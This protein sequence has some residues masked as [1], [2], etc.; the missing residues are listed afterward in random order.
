V[1][2]VVAAWAIAA[3]VPALEEDHGRAEPIA[4]AAGISRVAVVETA[5]PSEVV[6]GDLT[7]PARAAAVAVGLPA[8]ALGVEEVSRVVEAGVAAE[9]GADSGPDRNK[10]IQRSTNYELDICE[11][12]FPGTRFHAVCNRVGLRF[13]AGPV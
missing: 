12:Q 9:A 5:V 6:P 4:S 7:D 1:R 10:D 11:Y 13:R 3:A 2:V 8:W